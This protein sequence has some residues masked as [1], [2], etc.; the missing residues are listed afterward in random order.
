MNTNVCCPKEEQLF[1]YIFSTLSS[2]E[3]LELDSHFYYCFE[4]SHKMRALREAHSYLLSLKASTYMGQKYKEHQCDIAM[5]P[6]AGSDDLRGFSEVKSLNGRYTIR[7]IP[8][9][10]SSKAV[11]EV[12]LEDKNL[13]GTIQIENE[14]GVIFEAPLRKGVACQEVNTPIDLRS[15]L[16]SLKF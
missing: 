11:I 9:A 8:F 16:I 12:L 5:L 4:C 2:Q 10:N 14:H 7:I 3:T 6:A 13:E 15:I 1:K